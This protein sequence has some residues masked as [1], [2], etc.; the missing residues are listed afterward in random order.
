MR[1]LQTVVMLIGLALGC[2]SNGCGGP[3]T[4]AQVQTGISAAQALIT[5][6]GNVLSQAVDTSKTLCAIKTRDVEPRHADAR[7]QCA[8]INDAWKH[9]SAVKD[10][11]QVAI[12]SGDQT[13]IDASTA[14]LDKAVK[15]MKAVLVKSV[16]VT[17]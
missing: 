15:E 11:A 17:Q 12:D 14:K 13:K 2:G 7:F 10:E 5:I 9:V 4:P 1:E 6:I 16:A 8:E 3:I